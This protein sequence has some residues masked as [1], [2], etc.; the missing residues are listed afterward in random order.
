M[1]FKQKIG[2]VLEGGGQR[3]V[4][5]CG[6]LDYFLEQQ[7]YFPYVIGVSV[8]ASNSLSYISRQIGRN[9]KV[10]IQYIQDSRFLSF[11]NFLKLREY[12]WLGF[13]ISGITK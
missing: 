4:H 8:G 7:V 2:L 3:V 5:T 1:E 10:D 13:Y 12:I 6:I 11:K 9:W